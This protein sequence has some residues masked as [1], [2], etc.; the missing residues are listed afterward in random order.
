MRK[1][2]LVCLGLALAGCARTDQLTEGIDVV[3]EGRFLSSWLR[4]VAE[5]DPTVSGEAFAALE[6][7][8]PDQWEGTLILADA[9]K[10]PN[11]VVRLAAFKALGNI[12]PKAKAAVPVVEEGMLDENLTVRTQAI[13]SL[14]KITGVRKKQA[15]QPE[16]P[17]EPVVLDPP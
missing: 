6:R 14:L 13:R 9:A 3:H 7:V 16:G 15:T 2:W 8:G 1:T 17:P 10:D 5:D 11:P 12:G 4:E